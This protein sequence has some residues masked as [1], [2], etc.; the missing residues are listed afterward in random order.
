MI[1]TSNIEVQPLKIPS[2]YKDVGGIVMTDR[3]SQT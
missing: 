3:P 2:A 1:V